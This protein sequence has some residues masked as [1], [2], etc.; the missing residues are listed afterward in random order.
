MT[1]MLSAAKLV[2]YMSDGAKHEV[3]LKPRHVKA[4]QLYF[5]GKDPVDMEQTIY[6]CW[7][8]LTESGEYFGDLEAFELALDDIG[9]GEDD[10]DSPKA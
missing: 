10:E 3:V 6:T 4:I 2:V 1:G 5:R 9:V 7:L 8:V